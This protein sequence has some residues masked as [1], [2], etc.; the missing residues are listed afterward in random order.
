[1]G[2]GLTDRQTLEALELTDQGMS[3]ADV[4]EKLGVSR[5]SIVGIVSRCQKEAKPTPHD[6]TM[7][8][9]WWEAGLKKQERKAKQNAKAKGGKRA[10]S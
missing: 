10:A 2:R 6:G 8:A 9:R 5:M 7:P 3:R 1:M 4:A